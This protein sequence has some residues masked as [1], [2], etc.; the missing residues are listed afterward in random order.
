MSKI[1][2]YCVASESLFSDETF[3]LMEW[4]FL[5][6]DSRLFREGGV[7]VVMVMRQ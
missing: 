4:P 5:S 3:R 7:M 2:L 1:V 6:D